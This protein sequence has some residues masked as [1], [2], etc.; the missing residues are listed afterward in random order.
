MIF[1]SRDRETVVKCNNFSLFCDSDYSINITSEEVCE[2]DIILGKYSRIGDM[3]KAFSEIILHLERN[4]SEN[5]I[6]RVN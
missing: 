6:I 5:H 1:I 3:E 2:E 4:Y